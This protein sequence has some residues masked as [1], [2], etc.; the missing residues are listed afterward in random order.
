MNA[1]VISGGG[2]KGAFAGGVAEYL[3]VN[4]EK[5]YDLFVGTSTGSLLAPLLAAGEIELAKKIY[6]NVRQQDIFTVCPFIFKKNKDGISQVSINHWGII[7]MF[8][9]KEKTFGDSHNLRKLIGQTFTRQRFEKVRATGKEVIVTVSNLTLQE[10]E[11]KSSNEFEYED[12]C[13]WIWASASLV[14]FMSLVEKNGFDYGDGGFGNIIPIQAAINRGA[15]TADVIV[16]YPA[17]QQIKNPPIRNAFNVWNR[18][19]DYMLAQIVKDDQIIGNLEALHKKVA[20]KFYFT[21]R[22]LTEQSFVFDPEQMTAWW[23]EGYQLFQ[24]K[25]PINHAVLPETK[26]EKAH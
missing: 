18:T 9:R 21:P 10:L 15:T 4:C 20:L 12:F 24:D 26:P 25:T 16:L 2:S 1:L 19:Y 3:M 13:D 11:Y 14:P 8:W 17:T 7:K 22:L 23:E 6:T 5:N